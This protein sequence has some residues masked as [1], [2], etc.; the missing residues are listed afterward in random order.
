MVLMFKQREKQ[1]QTMLVNCIKT[2]NTAE[3][4]SN[5]HIVNQ[6]VPESSKVSNIVEDNTY[7]IF[8]SYIEI[9]N[10]YI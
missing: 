6:R 7:A 4:D 1:K 10:N 3:E 9:Y 5:P 8:V 2:P